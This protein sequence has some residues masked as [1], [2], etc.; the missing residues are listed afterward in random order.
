MI[1]SGPLSATPRK[2]HLLLRCLA[3]GAGI[4]V[5]MGLGSEPLGLHGLQWIAL[6]PLLRALDGLGRRDSILVGWAAGV[7]VNLALFT[8]VG[9]AFSDYGRIPG[10]L[11]VLAFLTFSI[12]AGL[13][14]ALLGLLDCQIRR[15]CPR[16]RFVLFPCALVATELIWPR[17]F[18]WTIGTPQVLNPVVSQVVDLVGPLGLSFLVASVN[19]GVDAAYVRRARGV[20]RAWAPLAFAGVLLT[21]AL[22]YGVARRAQ[23]RGLLDGARE[24]RVGWVQP[25]TVFQNTPSPTQEA[26]WT[27]IVDGM[28]ELGQLPPA[29]F[30]VLPESALPYPHI[31]RAPLPAGASAELVAED[32]E[33]REEVE[34]RLGLMKELG[35]LCGTTVLVGSTHHRIR[36]GGK[37]VW[38]WEEVRNS[39]FRV[40]AD[41]VRDRYDKRHLLAFGE[42]LP[43]ERAIPALRSLV[44]TAG[45]YVAGTGPRL[46]QAG[47][48]RVGP[49]IC[50]EAVWPR[51][52]RAMFEEG[53][54]D[55]LVNATNDVWFGTLQ[56]PQLHKMIVCLRA[57]EA[58]RSLVRVTTTGITVVVAPDGSVIDRAPLGVAAARVNEVPLLDLPP[59]LY[60]RWGDWLGW[61]ALAVLVLVRIRAR[62][63]PVRSTPELLSE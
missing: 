46:M 42:Y 22:T 10:G 58:R 3:A 2:K 41:G 44:P 23:V 49:L 15:R 37:D 62:P 63:S 16:A 35:R 20:A 25:N 6:V 5:C 57:L 18:P 45:D 21:V 55:V 26:V 51:E 28:A 8:W 53:S 40:T 43:L 19:A 56:G 52:V 59:G 60:M 31:E 61:L 30:C 12:L 48:V 34:F 36:A 9:T 17:V 11:S 4:S 33:L 29:A 32:G 13:E 50:Y 24:V 7:A 39:I 54:P 1:P 27:A 38:T 14:F 47:G